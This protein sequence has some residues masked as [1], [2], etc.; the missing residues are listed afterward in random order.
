MNSGTLTIYSA[1]AGSGKT[2]R[3]TKIY[4]TNLFR[5]RYNYRKIL[6]V[7]FTNKA[8]A[9][10]KGRILDQLYCLANGE[11][12]EYLDDLMTE[13]GRSEE[14]VREEAAG[15]LF[16]ILHDFSR[17][18]ISTIDSFFQKVI[19]S[20]A[21]E[22][23]LHAGFN[24]ELDH[25]IILS[26]AIDEMIASSV[27]DPEIRKWL[28]DY[29]M[30]NLEEEKSW[31]LKSEITKLAE[32]LFRE[33]F[34]ILSET[35]R[36][37]LADKSFLRDYIKK[38]RDLTSS[39][40][41]TVEDFAKEL[42]AIYA[43]FELTDDMFYGKSRGIPSFI[44]SLANGR[45]IPANNTVR[46]IFEDKPRW[47]AKEP[48]PQLMSA[49][50]GGLED[51]LR[52]AITYLDENLT[53]YNTAKAISPNVYALGILSDVL[54]KVRKVASDENSFLI[55]DAGELL[56]LI[57]GNDQA[58]FIYEKIGNHYENYMIDEFQDT[59]MLQWKNFNPLID[60]SMGRGCDNLIVGDIKQSIYRWR[61][62]DWRILA[63]LQIDK[64]DNERFF[65]KPLVN[66]WRSRSEIIRFNNA[67][68]SLIPIQA[69]RYF[70][71]N[72]FRSDFVNLYTGA[73]QSDPGKRKG[74]YVRLDIVDIDHQENDVKDQ[75][76]KEEKSKRWKKIVVDRIPGVIEMFQDH[77]YQASDI[78]IIVREVKEGEAVVRR[79][80]DYSNNCPSDKRAKY[81]YEVVSDDS[82]AL[83]SSHAINFIIAVLRLI[84][85]P[86]DMISRA[87]M[88][89]FYSLSSGDADAGKLS[90]YKDT[91]LNGSTGLFPEDYGQ[92]LVK[93]RNRPLFEITEGIIS[94]F[95]LGRNPGNVAYLT[96]FQDQVLNFSRSKS[97]DTDS[98][99]DW[100][101]TTG[102]RKSIS[103]PSNQN[104]ARILTIHKAKG[105]EFKVVILPFLSWNLDYISGKQPVL[106]IKPDVSPFNDLGIVPVRYGS[107]LASTIFADE[108]NKEKYFSYIDNI[109]LLY[110]A[111]TRAR[112]ALYGFVP[113]E[114]G[115]SSTIAGTIKNA[116]SSDENPAGNQGM[117]LKEYF[118]SEKG[119]FEFGKIP[120]TTERQKESDVIISELYHVNNRPESFRLRLHGENYF[121]PAKETTERK[122]N[123]GNLMHEVFEG[124]STAADIPSAINKLVREGKIP[125]SGYS[126]LEKKLNSLVSSPDV[127]L[128]FAPGNKI[129][130]ETEILT[131]SGNT[132]RPDRVIISD[133]K[134]TVIDFKFGEEDRKHKDQS[135]H[136]RNLLAAMGYENTEA[137]IWYVDK[138]KIVE[139]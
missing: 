91:L 33:K 25:S 71:E 39:V 100:W 66:N 119:V 94:Y 23:G 1:S 17:F 88:L 87:Q 28:T 74:G 126:E 63:G 29:V 86:E 18:S 96:T 120:G 62:S 46:L 48:S 128:W 13:T 53:F 124:I 14:K 130:K 24:I 90:L 85:D 57:T 26:S 129:F 38:I 37:K 41:K 121:S 50:H 15:L 104:A 12:S 89:R 40:E 64:V 84:C 136:Y 51:T 80:I 137:F 118:D 35:E 30:R 108:Y 70:S 6:A 73:V 113:G 127:A 43:R 139:V 20:F 9:E 54:G 56:S 45:I 61:N 116:L 16:S 7:T 68:F 117:A 114:T 8:T 77:G 59:S 112:D 65:S 75:C 133:G 105:L 5:S 19:R 60:E 32:E 109:N 72:G 115:K 10:M 135:L 103:L 78:G 79:L 67:L 47:S 92:F 49:I 95:G 101:E 93:M 4:L 83:S 58:P 106:W 110:V 82:L 22:T 125:A 36:E 134:A 55:S 69:D 107:L 11:K 111:M 132:R 21:R 27:D 34:K 44:K 102:N 97:S 42:N 131:Q 122:I 98:F 52:K 81:N 2:F 138:N 76:E 99:L 123:Y 31:N 3:L